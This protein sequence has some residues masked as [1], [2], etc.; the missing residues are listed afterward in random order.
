MRTATPET[1]NGRNGARYLPTADARGTSTSAAIPTVSRIAISSRRNG[2]G[3]SQT[4][5]GRKR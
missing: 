3:L 4:S 5:E 1:T 2:I